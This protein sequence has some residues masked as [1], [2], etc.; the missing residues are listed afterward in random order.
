M[1]SYWVK[2]KASL[3]NCPKTVLD[4]SFL[5]VYNDSVS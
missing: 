2:Y 5:T 4:L 3:K 1:G